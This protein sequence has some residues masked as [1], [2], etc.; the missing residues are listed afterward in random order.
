LLEE[1]YNFED[2][3]VVGGVLLT[4]MNNADRVKAACLAQLVNVIG[5]IMTETGGPA[6]RQTIFHP[7]AQTSRHG[8]GE[9][10]RLKVDTGSFAGGAHEAAPLLLASVV[11]DPETGAATIF[12]LN[13]GAEPMGLTLELRGL[14]ERRI[15]EAT[16]L[17]HADL[18]AINS[19]AAPDAVAPAPHPAARLDGATLTA[20]LKPYSWNVVATASP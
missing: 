16:E 19:K 6:W 5:P 20:Q 15:V 7:F 18:K 13:R 14:G 17:H 2:A 3:L 4:L 8:R 10:L 9:V 12:A 1:I 11:H